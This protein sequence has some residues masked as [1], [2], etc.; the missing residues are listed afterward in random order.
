MR[1][2]SVLTVRQLTSGR[3]RT[4]GSRQWNRKV[5][6]QRLESEHSGGFCYEGAPDAA[7]R[8]GVEGYHQALQW[9]DQDVVHARRSFA[10][11]ADFNT[12]LADWL[13]KANAR[14]QDHKGSPGRSDRP[15]PFKPGIGSGFCSHSDR[16][17][18]PPHDARTGAA[19]CRTS[20]LGCVVA[21]FV[22]GIRVHIREPASPPPRTGHDIDVVPAAGCARRRTLS[23]CF[24]PRARLRA[25]SEASASAGTRISSVRTPVRLWHARGTA[26]S[27]QAGRPLTEAEASAVKARAARC[28]PVKPGEAKLQT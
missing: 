28:R 8:S 24:P 19:G 15:R 3:R 22:V 27:I 4:P 11:S 7:I 2:Q 18:H 6:T 10:S 20:S 13:L 16:L 25:R 14:G 5:N 1:K 9:P 26:D 21:G 12:Q 23:L 17:G